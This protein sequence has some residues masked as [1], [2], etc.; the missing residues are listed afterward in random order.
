MS[1]FKSSSRSY[2]HALLMMVLLAAVPL[3]NGCSCMNPG[4]TGAERADTIKNNEWTNLVVIATFVDETRWTEDDH[5]FP[6]DYQNTTFTVKEI[7]YQRNPD[8]SLDNYVDVLPDGTMA[9][10]KTTVT[11]CCLCGHELSV[12]DIGSDY[13]LEISEYGDSFSICSASCRYSDSRSDVPEWELSR[14]ELC[15][16]TA[17]ELRGSST[18]KRNIPK[19]EGAKASAFDDRYKPNTQQQ[20][21]VFVTSTSSESSITGAAYTYKL[22]I[23]TSLP[24]EISDGS[25]VID[26]CVAWQDGSNDSNFTWYGLRLQLDEDATTGSGGYYTP[27]VRATEEM[28]YV[29]QYNTTANP[30]DYEIRTNKAQPTIRINY[31][32]KPFWQTFKFDFVDK[33]G[34]TTASVSDNNDYQEFNITMDG[35]IRCSGDGNWGL[36]PV[37]PTMTISLQRI[38]GGEGGNTPT[39]VPPSAAA[40]ISGKWLGMGMSSVLA[41]W[42]LITV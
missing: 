27:I 39:P 2:L 24:L 14:E 32:D 1:S 36:R 38:G 12:E 25:P 37:I 21:D 18:P 13:L 19:L 29:Q 34:G 40:V 28:G 41:V 16:D 9:V 11:T 42:S 10:Q 35:T 33:Q 23:N 20:E 4:D 8:S 7:V 17:A 30:L 15:H 22:F 26:N 5:G 3:V 6:T 31:N